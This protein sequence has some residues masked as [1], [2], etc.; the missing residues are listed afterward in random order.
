MLSRKEESRSTYALIAKT[1]LKNP[2]VSQSQKKG[3]GSTALW[4]N[5][6]IFVTLSAKGEFVAKLPRERV[7]QLVES[8]EGKLWDPRGNGRVMKEWTVFDTAD[9]PKLLSIAKQA[10]EYAVA[11]LK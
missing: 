3:F 8:G 11:K 4:A 10:L 1:L 9:R 2:K 7:K 6:R 5:G